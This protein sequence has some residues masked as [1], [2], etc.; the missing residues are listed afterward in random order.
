MSL[1]KWAQCGQVAE[2]Y[3]MTGTPVASPIANSGNGPG[4]S[5]FAMSTLASGFGAVSPKAAP[6]IA[7][8]GSMAA[9]R[10]KLRRERGEEAG[11]LTVD[12]LRRPTAQLARQDFGRFRVGRQGER[13]AQK[14]G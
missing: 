5:A 10:T 3:S 7:R 12:P 6:N 14:F 11:K 9:A 4:A 8:L 2:P 13:S 1:S